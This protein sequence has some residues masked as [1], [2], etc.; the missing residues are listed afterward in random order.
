MPYLCQRHVPITGGSS[1]FNDRIIKMKLFVCSSCANMVFFESR[2][3]EQCASRLGYLPA[4]NSLYALEPAGTN[5]LSIG[6]PAQEFRFCANVEHDACN[7]LIP[8][9]SADEL[10]PACRHNHTIPDLSVSEN[11]YRWRKLE[12]AKHHLFYDL[13]RSRLPLETRQD[14]PESGLS[15]EFLDDSLP[16]NEKVLTGHADGVITIN[17]AEA[18]DVTREQR[19]TGLG[20]PY[21]TLI[22]HFRHEIGHYY[23]DHLVRDGGRLE[24]FRDCFGDETQDYDNALQTYYAEGPPANWRE[25][26]VSA[27]ASSHPWEDFAETWAHFLHIVD[28]LEMAGSFGMRVNPLVTDQQAYSAEIDFDPH[29][30]VTIDQ[31]VRQWLPIAT[32]VNSINRCMGQPDLYPFILTAAVIRKLGFVHDLVRQVAGASQPLEAEPALSA[33]TA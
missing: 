25:N 18:D 7:W 20:E 29:A 28:T 14:N 16:Q 1:S 32:A 10:C 2:T 13:L 6:T 8:S 23:W 4:S 33:G 15:F 3:C 11:L 26:F 22:G 21:R 12:Q 19:R 30:T 9:D 31:L 27:Y 24:D 5:W 17:L